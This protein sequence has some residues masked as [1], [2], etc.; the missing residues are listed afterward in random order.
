MSRPPTYRCP[1]T[2]SNPST[3]RLTPPPSNQA[4]QTRLG[5]NPELTLDLFG[6]LENKSDQNDEMTLAAPSSAF[7]LSPILAEVEKETRKMFPFEFLK[8][9]SSSSLFPFFQRI[10]TFGIIRGIF[11]MKK[12]DP[13]NSQN[14]PMFS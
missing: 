13:T 6:E 4:L 9:P 14:F 8:V 11:G 10:S 7:S 3:P 12:T 1:F 5:K 2:S